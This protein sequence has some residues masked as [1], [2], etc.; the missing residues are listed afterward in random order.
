MFFVYTCASLFFAIPRLQVIATLENRFRVYD[1]RTR[2]PEEGYAHL[3]EK[4][5]NSTV[6]LGRHLPQ[7]RDLF[8][9]TGGNGTVNV[10][11]YK[12]PKQRSRK[13]TLKRDKHHCCISNFTLN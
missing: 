5:H 9:T 3:S 1:M 6:W 4:A 2:H 7:N 10:Y 11:K 13:G 8:A 12:Y